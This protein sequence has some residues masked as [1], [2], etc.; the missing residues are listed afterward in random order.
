MLNLT[1]LDLPQKQKQI[2]SSALELFQRFGIR[3]ISI[4]E[5]CQTAGVSKMTFYKYYNNKNDLVKFIWGTGIE[6]GMQRF[7]EI[8]TMDIPFEKKLRLVLQLKDETTTKI[9][10]DFALDYFSASDD[11][12]EF[13]QGLIH[14]TITSFLQ[15]IKEAQAN[16]DV[17][18]DLKAEFLL[19]VI[20]HI[21]SMIKDKNLINLYPTYHDFVMEV[22]NFIFYGILS[23]PEPEQNGS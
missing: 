18:P 19:T 1:K 8:K 17:R 4:E 21:Q 5:L 7:E 9:S 23:R 14:K 20:N 15:F 13:F 12:N 2:V 10:H 11:L 6:Q 16:G 22:N 3:R